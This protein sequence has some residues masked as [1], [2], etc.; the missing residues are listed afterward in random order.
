MSGALVV[1]EY[2]LPVASG[3]RTTVPAPYIH[4]HVAPL[5]KRPGAPLE[6]GHSDWVVV[7]GDA[8]TY[9]PDARIIFPSS[10]GLI[11]DTY[12]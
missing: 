8:L 1:F 2:Q 3:T 12:A 5:A 10:R 9:G 7:E 11:L 6:S 4:R